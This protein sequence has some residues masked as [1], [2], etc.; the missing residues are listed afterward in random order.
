MWEGMGPALAA[1]KR[2][3]MMPEENFSAPI[4]ALAP[5]T[6]RLTRRDLNLSAKD[7]A[8]ARYGAGLPTWT[9][10]W[11]RLGLENLYSKCTNVNVGPSNCTIVRS[12]REID[13]N[14][15]NASVCDSVNVNVN[16]Y[17]KQPTNRKRVPLT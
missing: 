4:A 6:E 7:V 3:R 17:R 16:V 15:M 13:V 8:K 1:V 5:H 12:C 10:V 14:C 2:S 9:P 11:N